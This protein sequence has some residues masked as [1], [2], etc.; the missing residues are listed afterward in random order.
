MR[1]KRE[2][3]IERVKKINSKIEVKK[4]EIKMEQGKD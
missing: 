4:R 2:R 1:K 3:E